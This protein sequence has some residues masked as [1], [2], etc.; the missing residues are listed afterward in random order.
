MTRPTPTDADFEALRRT[1]DGP[2]HPFTMARFEALGWV[3]RAKPGAYL[4]AAFGWSQVAHETTEAG[5][6]AIREAWRRH[7]EAERKRL[8]E[9]HTRAL[10]SSV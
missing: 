4:A 6:E 7:H 5:V 8:A 1:S 10:P 9:Q 3:E 2:V